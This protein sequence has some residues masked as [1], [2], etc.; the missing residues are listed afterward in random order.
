MLRWA[1]FAA[2]A[3]FTAATLPA[4]QPAIAQDNGPTQT[5]EIC[6][7]KVFGAPVTNANQL[8][9]TAN[10]IRI[11][12]V[13]EDDQGNPLV[14][15]SSC[16]EGTEFT[17]EA[18]FE[19][20][21]TANSRYDAGF[22]FRIDGT[23]TA[24]GD[25]TAASGLCSL[26]GLDPSIPPALALDTDSC[27]DL[28]SGIYHV[29]FTI[30]G[31]ECTGVP[32]PENPGKKILRLPNCTSWHNNQGTSCN[33]IDPFSFDP[34]T[35][36]KCVCDDEF[37]VPVLVETASL[38]VIKDASPTTVPETGGTVTYG[39]QVTNDAEFVSV[40][41]ATLNDDIYG[42]IAD[43]GCDEAGPPSPC[44]GNITENT[45]DDLVGVVLG[46]GDMDSCS[47]KAFV[48][49]DSGDVVTDVVDVCGDQTNTDDQI[50]GD[51]DADV[52]VTDVP[53]IPALA[54]S[55]QTASCTVD[56]NY[57]VVVSN[58]SVVDDTLTVDSLTDD[59]FGDITQ[60]QGNVI[61]TTCA[62]G[63]QI[64]KGAN[65]TCSFVGRIDTGSGPC[66]IDHTDKVTGGVSDDDGQSYTPM[67]SATVKV[68]TTFP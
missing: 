64:A 63:A 23:G 36:A 11:S 55:A 60:V 18:T 10:D 67:D 22:F 57:Q 65:Y 59:K 20:D 48:S 5:G 38:T 31:V 4:A 17:L 12:G 33:I 9:C 1:R 44:N 45:C 49:G 16:L 8:N 3:G 7:Q 2:V 25:G 39:V 61:S 46:P 37:T 40:E 68:N 21:V 42:N 15:P 58:N 6:M 27:G 13:A 32:D 28:N 56:V 14:S 66:S 29:S 35:K 53:A 41:I 52:T 50:C 43:P 54:K 24:R 34:D 62:T 30:P 51:D 26:S 47:F 19:V